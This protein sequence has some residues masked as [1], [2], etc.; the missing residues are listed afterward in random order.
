MAD[1]TLALT[2]TELRI[3]IADLLGYSRT[4]GNWSVEEGNIIDRCLNEGTSRFYGEK[5]WNWLRVKTTILTVAADYDQDLPDN[6]L[7]LI[8]DTFEYAANIGYAPV[9]RTSPERIYELLSQ[10]SGSGTMQWFAIEAK[11][12]TGA[13]GTRYQVIWYPPPSTAYTMTYRYR[14]DRDALSASYPY[15][16]GGVA[17]RN[18]ILE[19]CLAAAEAKLDRI[20]LHEQRYR[21]F[22]EQALRAD[23]ANSPPY[24]GQAV[25]GATGRFDPLQANDH[26]AT[27]NGSLPS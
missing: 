7:E 3:E 25:Q 2:R 26:Y 8:G 10:S 18:A 5:T 12:Q 4:A 1:S 27:Y 13:T 15:P 11:T 6:F 17:S 20:G 23:A 19:A 9:Q 16:A 21:M 14:L 22:L 24:I